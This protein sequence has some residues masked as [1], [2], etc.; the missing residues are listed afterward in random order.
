MGLVEYDSSSSS[1]SFEDEI[2]TASKVLSFPRALKRD[3]NEVKSQYP[4]K[5]QQRL[6]SLP[7]SF[8]TAPK[9]DPSLHQGR[10]RTRPFVDGE[11]NS[12]VYL[13]LDIPSKLRLILEQVISTFQEELP[14]YTIH[15]S[16]SS[17]H[18]SLTH[19]LPLRRDQIIPFRDQLADRLRIR[20]Q[21]SLSFAGGIKVYYNRSMKD[22]A[23]GEEG[24]GGRAFLALRLGAGAIE[25]K[26][27]VE[28]IIHPPIDI[29]HL[30][31]YHD[32]PEFHTSFAWTLLKPSITSKGESGSTEPT[33]VEDIPGPPSEE[34]LIRNNGLT[35]F[36]DDM[37]ER[38][39]AKFEKKILEAQPKGGWEIDNVH[40]KAAKD[41]HV[42][43]IGK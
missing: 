11:Y 32:N 2:F 36:P 40:F 26:E 13:S 17:L 39:K 28:Q 33:R 18:I 30:P 42:L 9:D 23:H 25:V 5:R 38:I 21:F 6:P 22:G 1:S 12:H 3:I 29:I 10:S 37:L 34:E 8:H 19:P 31:K 41:I 7:D 15:S 27:I 43:P 16:L 24:S 35:P 14:T 4:A 20:K